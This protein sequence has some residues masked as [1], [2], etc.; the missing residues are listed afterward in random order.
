VECHSC[1]YLKGNVIDEKD[2]LKFLCDNRIG[3]ISSPNLGVYNPA[4]WPSE[5]QLQQEWLHI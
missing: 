5:A 1:A 4:D 2:K 3:Q